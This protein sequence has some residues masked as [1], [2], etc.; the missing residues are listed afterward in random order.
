MTETPALVFLDFRVAPSSDGRVLLQAAAFR[1]EARGVPAEW[2]GEAAS[3]DGAALARAFA[4]LI[5]WLKS[6]L[7]VTWGDPAEARERFAMWAAGAPETPWA[8]L[9]EP[10]FVAFPEAAALGLRPLVRRLLGVTGPVVTPYERAR[11]LA[12]L[13]PIVARGVGGLPKELRED[14]ARLMRDTEW[15]WTYLL[16]S[17]FQVPSSK[18]D[19]RAGGELET[20]NQKPETRDSKPPDP[21][22]SITPDEIDALFSEGGPFKTL[23]PDYLRRPGQVAMA[24]GVAEA[25]EGGQH[26]VVEAGT[27][28]GKSFAYL[29]P[30]LLRGARRGRPILVSTHTRSLQDQLESEGIP[31]VRELLGRPFRTAVLKGRANYLCLLREEEF[32]AAARSLHPPTGRRFFADDPERDRFD[33]ERLALFLI[34]VWSARTTRGELRDELPAWLLERLPADLLARTTIDAAH[35]P[36]RKCPRYETCHVTRAW[37]RAREA[38]VVIL[39]HALL[40]ETLIGGREENLPSAETVV[41]DEAHHLEAV[42]TE[43][44]TR[45]SSV[46]RLERLLRD[47]KTDRREG[48]VLGRLERYVAETGENGRLARALADPVR[49]AAELVEPARASGHRF[50]D[51]LEDFVRELPRPAMMAG[52]PEYGTKLTLTHLLREHPAWEEVA[53]RERDY[54]EELNRLLARLGRALRPLAEAGGDVDEETGSTEPLPFVLERSKKE[55][56][57]AVE[58]LEELTGLHEEA[59]DAPRED[60]VYWLE[61]IPPSDGDRGHVLLS[62][63][64][65]SVGKALKL[66]LYDKIPTLVLTSATLA[67]ATGADPYRSLK[68]RLGFHALPADRARFERVPSPFDYRK[69]VMF[70]VPSDLPAYGGGRAE[71]RRGYFGA[72][73]AALPPL[74]RANPGGALVLCTSHEQVD[75][76]H[77]AARDALAGTGVPAL[78]QR[79]GISTR[80]LVEEFREEGRA[81]LVG[82]Y[83]LWEGIDVPGMAL[84]MVLMAKL[85]FDPPGDPLL[86]ARMRHVETLEDGRVFQG[87]RDVYYPI[88][89]TRLKQGFGRLIRRTTDRGVIVLFDERILTSRAYS[90]F[91]LQSLPEGLK[92]MATPLA[93]MEG[94]IRKFF[95]GEGGAQGPT[96]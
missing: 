49:E 87:M 83:S 3:G 2:A 34:R 85:P 70:L 55:L 65:V 8:D 16:S 80:R 14:G 21:T 7:A 32:A 79:R 82:T 27:G 18:L 10:A 29:V 4:P 95:A 66:S 57:S 78:R 47:L 15:P 94:E 40:L 76:F 50:Y 89:I 53:R 91:F 44:L 33:R 43:V 30:A 62:A 22:A 59:S 74:L 77:A 54:R 75:R 48:G 26:F 56:A 64:P 37:N 41:L 88:A 12:D 23:K 51:V 5:D 46:P 9:R 52:S 69:Q 72:I 28:V 31:V 61:Q 81:V 60:F 68:A 6:G 35:C 1:R 92:P 71:T 36:G 19:Q 38:D 67:A 63:A 13:Y 73:E 86:E 90:G 25:M 20:R 96:G 42:A 24:R 45:E 93:G 11:A 58:D 84:S 39:N 17:K